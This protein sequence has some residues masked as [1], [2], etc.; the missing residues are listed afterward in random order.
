MCLQRGAF[1]VAHAVLDAPAAS[2][3][4]ETP[5][6][7]R[8]VTLSRSKRRAQRA[9]RPHD[10]G[11]RLEQRGQ[12]WTVDLRPW[13]GSRYTPLRNPKDAGWPARGGRTDSQDVAERWKWAYVDRVAD[14]R[15][16]EHLGRR[17]RGRALND[18]VE[19]FLEARETQ[20]IAYCTRRGDAT[21]L[22]S[23][24]VRTFGSDANVEH[25]E[26]GPLQ[27]LFDELARAGYRPGTLE[28]YAHAMGA[29]FAWLGRRDDDNPARLLT[30]PD[31][32]DTEARTFSDDELVAIR[33]AADAIDSR[34]PCQHRPPFSMRLAVE[35]G[36][37]TGGRQAELFA[38]DWSA[39]RERS[40]TVRFTLQLARD[41]IG[42]GDGLKGLKGKE[43][44]TTLVLPSWWDHHR[45]TA[46]GRVLGNEGVRGPRILHTAFRWINTLY[47]IAGVNAEGQAWHAL[48][49]TYS[50]LFLEAGGRL[51]EL[52]HSLGHASI[53]TTERCY[54]HF[55]DDAAATLARLRIYGGV[56]SGVATG[57]KR[58]APTA[59]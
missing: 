36:L 51:E 8:A 37:G 47:D 31:P 38:L 20:Q 54:G 6:T 26:L 58:V 53:Q 18:A 15:K 39:F 4:A 29:F 2:P 5:G 57:P 40:C 35:I 42:R 55:S 45:A 48:R 19:A 34:G 17:P 41:A 49:H 52:Q 22:Q 24:L 43:A 10:L 1:P 32:E 14:D 59:K 12:W 28:R 21:A 13:G 23:H 16:R 25:I 11:P 9:H 50:R 56:V 7:G 30:L 44:R 27:Q 3:A 46:R 33:K